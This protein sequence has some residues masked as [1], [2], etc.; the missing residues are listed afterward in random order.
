MLSQLSIATDNN[1]VWFIPIHSRDKSLS[2]VNFQ[3]IYEINEIINWQFDGNVLG[4][5]SEALHTVRAMCVRAVTPLQRKCLSNRIFSFALS[6][7][8]CGVVKDDNAKHAVNSK[9]FQLYAQ[10]VTVRLCVFESIPHHQMWMRHSPMIH[11]RLK[12]WIQPIQTTTKRW[13]HFL[14]CTLSASGRFH[15][16]FS[17]SS[18]FVKWIISSLWT[19]EPLFR[20]TVIPDSYSGSYT[21]HARTK[22]GCATKTTKLKICGN[23]F[24][25]KIDVIFSL[26]RAPCVRVFDRNRKGL[27]DEWCRQNAFRLGAMNSRRPNH[28]HT[29]AESKI[30]SDA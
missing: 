20:R 13:N 7:L 4:N 21:R 23:A 5:Y 8:I 1:G 17:S 29:N 16:I 11:K 10:C 14:R 3:I 22:F 27:A 18:S 26:N 12:N 19:K 6:Y 9:D 30:W 2:L 24:I 25:Q 28:S 15:D